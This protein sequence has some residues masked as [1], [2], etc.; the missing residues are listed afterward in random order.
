MS[1][2]AIANRFTGQARGVT[3]ASAQ[4]A[5]YRRGGHRRSAA[6]G[7][8]QEILRV[9]GQGTHGLILFVREEG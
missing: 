1:V 6:K 4:A 3:A 5:I 2:I 7:A 9:I 8:G